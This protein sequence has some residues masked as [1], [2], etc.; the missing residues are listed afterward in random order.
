MVARPFLG[1]RA[2]GMMRA[3]AS[4]SVFKD[5]KDPSG[6]PLWLHPLPFQLLGL[7]ACFPHYQVL[8]FV[9]WFSCDSLRDWSAHGKEW[10]IERRSQSK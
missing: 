8:P 5:Y 7:V 1:H 10:V 3:H 6:L 9:F 2:I 4:F